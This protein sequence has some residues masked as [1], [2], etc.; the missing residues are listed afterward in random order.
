LLALD[1]RVKPGSVFAGRYEIVGL[2]GQ[3]G[4]GKVYRAR[5]RT[6]RKDLAIKVLATGTHDFETRFEREARAIA[7]LDHPNCVRVLDYGHSNGYHF[8]AMELLQGETLGSALRAGPL[9]IV[10]A[11]HVARGVLSALGHAHRHGILHRDVKPENIVLAGGRAVLIDFGLAAL[12]DEAS[13]TGAGMC[14]GSPSYIAPERLLGRRF[15]GRT[16]LYAV[17]VILYE[18]LAG[19]RPF[20]GKSPEETMNLAL[21]RPARPLRALRRDLPR[22]LDLVVQRALAKEP[23]R[24]FADAEDMLLALGDV[25]VLDDEDPGIVLQRAEEASTTALVTFRQPPWWMRLWGWLRYG[26]WRWA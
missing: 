10:R 26:G 25:P 6:L 14:L 7:R 17:G 24:R 2:L 15:D 22:G 11:L 3:G 13:M 1:D 12:C 8:I 20:N 4:M 23:E 9:S 5:H 18:M 21:R 16:D 19:V